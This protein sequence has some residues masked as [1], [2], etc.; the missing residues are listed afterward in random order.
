[1]K[2]TTVSPLALS[3]VVN[4]VWFLQLVVPNCRP[5]CCRCHSQT[6]VG[7]GSIYCAKFL[8]TWH[9]WCG[10]SA[11]ASERDADHALAGFYLQSIVLNVE[12]KSDTSMNARFSLHRCELDDTRLGSDTGITKS[13]YVSYMQILICQYQTLYVTLFAVNG[14]KN[15]I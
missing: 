4:E 6:G 11:G 2:E 3:A 1:M 9:C 7:P 14:R 5:L 10:Q 15:K 8:L 12:M 13:V